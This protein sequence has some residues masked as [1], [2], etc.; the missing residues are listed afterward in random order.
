M[1]SYATTDAATVPRT[2]EERRHPQARIAY[3][4][5]E[6]AKTLGISR[7]TIYAMMRA[8]ALRTA[9]AGA[10]RLVPAAELNRLLSDLDDE[11]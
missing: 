7:S 2:R 5:A 11:R 9:K 3:S 8:G 6:T 4:P 1:T 10:R